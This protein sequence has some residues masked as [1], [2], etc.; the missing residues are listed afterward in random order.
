MT[1]ERKEEL[2]MKSREDFEKGSYQGFTDAAQFQTAVEDYWLGV[3]DAELERRNT[4]VKIKIMN[5]YINMYRYP[6]YLRWKD[7]QNQN[8][9]ML[10][11]EEWLASH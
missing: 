10:T 9:P 6:E 5:Q 2:R 11:Y 7:C 3:I 1:P 4:P 8:T